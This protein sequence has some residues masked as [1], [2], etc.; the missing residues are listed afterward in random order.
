MKRLAGLSRLAGERPDAQATL[1]KSRLSWQ[2][3]SWGVIHEPIPLRCFPCYS[4]LN[5]MRR[6]SWLGHSKG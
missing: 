1:E 5:F 4:A 3:L 2:G 6:A